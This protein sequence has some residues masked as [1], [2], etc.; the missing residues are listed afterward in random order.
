MVFAKKGSTNKMKKKFVFPKRNPIYTGPTIFGPGVKLSLWYK[1]KR[2][3][4]QLWKDM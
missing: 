1:I 3:L 4:K 2:Y